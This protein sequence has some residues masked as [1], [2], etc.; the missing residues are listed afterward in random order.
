MHCLQV[1]EYDFSKPGFGPATGHFTQM[2]WADT[3]SVGCGYTACPDGVQ[4]LGANTG[5]LVCQYW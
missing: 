2:V 5:V 1:C 4:G 3:R